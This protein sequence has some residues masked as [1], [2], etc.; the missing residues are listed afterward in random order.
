V[1]DA[2]LGSFVHWI[3]LASGMVIL[4]PGL[5][6]VDSIEELANGHLASGGARMAGVGVAFLALI[7]GVLLA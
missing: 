6:L 3:P 5:S 1:A 4:L 7:F 2:Y